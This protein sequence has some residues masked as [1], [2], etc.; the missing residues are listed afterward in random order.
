M[1]D[2]RPGGLFGTEG[3]HQAN[4]QQDCTGSE[5]SSDSASETSSFFSE[6]SGTGFDRDTTVLGATATPGTILGVVPSHI[7]LSPPAGSAPPLPDPGG[8]TP[9]VLGRQLPLPPPHPP[10]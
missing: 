4:E 7:P 2:A 3:S 6:S 1:A 5:S 8:A 10:P 9:R